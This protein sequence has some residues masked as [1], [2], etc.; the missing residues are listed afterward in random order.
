MPRYPKLLGM[1]EDEGTAWVVQGDTATIIG[2]NKAFVYGG[3]D[4]NDPGKP[5]LTLH[6]GDRYNLATRHVMHRA[7]EDSPVTMA[8]VNGLFAKYTNPQAG[9]ATVLVARNG[10]VFVDTSYGVPAQPKYMPTTTL[11]QFPLGAMSGVFTALCA[12]LPAPAAR[13]RAGAARGAAGTNS[14]ARRVSRMT[15]FQRC[16]ARQ[17]GTP[18]GFH[19]TTADS[20]GQVSSDVDE[21]YRLELGL[22]NPKTWPGADLTRGWSKETHGGVRWLTAYGSKDGK[23]N[24]FVRIPDKRAVV[25][26]LTNDAAADAKGMAEQIAT[27]LVGGRE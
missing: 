5:F 2:R 27:R 19:R 10:E 18:I 16:V 23:R 12:Q 17:V 7:S 20:A 13:R 6:P 1:S 25:I 3:R 15:P 21:L 4:G 8:F 22:E 14:R 24:A 9:G 26:V 11:P